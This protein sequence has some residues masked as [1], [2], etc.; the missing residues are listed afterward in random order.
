MKKVILFLVFSVVISSSLFAQKNQDKK[1]NAYVEAV[2]SKTTLTSKEKE[3]IIALKTV[4]VKAT[5]EIN[6][7]YEKGSEELKEK[8]RESN[9]EFSKS[10]TKAFGKQRAKEIMNASKKKKK[11]KKK[12]K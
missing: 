12:N 8:R 3:T 4:H 7:K 5:S 10:L 1:V 9:K 11:N 6:E 2:E